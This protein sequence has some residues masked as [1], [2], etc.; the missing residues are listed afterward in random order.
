[1]MIMQMKMVTVLQ[2]VV[3]HAHQ[4]L[5]MTQIMMVFA[6]AKISVLALTIMQMQMVTE[7][8]MVVMFVQ[9]MQMTMQITMAFVVM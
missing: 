2:M 9:T 7:Q 1:M 5:V 3:T 4:M 6:T 8:L